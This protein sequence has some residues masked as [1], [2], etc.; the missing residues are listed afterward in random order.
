MRKNMMESSLADVTI[1]REKVEKK[2]RLKFAYLNDEK[3]LRYYFSSYD[4]RKEEENMVKFWAEL[5]KYLFLDIFST[6][7]MKISEI[8]EYTIIGNYIPNGLNNIIQELRI[9]QK[10]ILDTD[11]N[12]KEFFVKNFPELNTGDNSSQGWGSYLFSGVKK[13][14]DLGS[15][16][17]GCK[18]NNNED[19]NLERREDISEDEKYKILPNN[20]IV[21]NYEL[22]KNN[23]GQLLSFL[24]DILQQNDNDIILKNEFINEVNNISSNNSGGLYN[25]INLYFGS[26]YID[27]CLKYLT[28][29]KKIFIFSVQEN[30]QKF[31][32]IKL[33]INKYDS[34]KDKDIIIAKLLIKS[35]SLQIKINEL[36]Q[37]INFC[38]NSAKDCIRKGDKRGGKQFLIKKKQYEK[39]K[40]AYDNTYM[41]IIQN[42]LDI[43]NAENNVNITEILKSCNNLFD[44]IGLDRNEFL[45]VSEEIKEKKDIQNEMSNCLKQFAD[46]DDENLDEELKKLEKENSKSNNNDKGGKKLEFPRPFDQPINPFSSEC[47]ELYK[48]K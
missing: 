39:Y 34:L 40:E 17:F 30:N 43:K 7:G 13:L 15:Y 38:I 23:S 41:I 9:Q 37:R 35:N 1:T 46:D 31:E 16:N 19:V 4:F 20:T 18:E 6:F 28:N 36:E 27:Y 14:V 10:I 47:Q 21:F 26:I 25:G 12:N 24:S 8:K 3:Q 22:L 29:I 44:K 33:M 42:M 11:I 45:D 48:Q 32:F 5:L 2:I